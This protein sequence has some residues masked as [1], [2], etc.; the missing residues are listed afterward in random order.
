MGLFSGRKRVFIAY[1]KRIVEKG[2]AGHIFHIEWVTQYL[3][4]I[5]NLNSIGR[6]IRSTFKAASIILEY[7]QKVAK[8]SEIDKVLIVESR[9]PP[10]FL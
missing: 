9:A 8:P 10:S 2:S 1:L 4:V 7:S 5:V 6:L 3:K